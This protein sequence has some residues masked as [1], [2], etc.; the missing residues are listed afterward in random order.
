M[1]G[2]G[3][4]MGKGNVCA[5]RVGDGPGAGERC[6]MVTV[7]PLLPLEAVVELFASSPTLRRFVSDFE[8]S[9]IVG[10]SLSTRRSLFNREGPKAGDEYRFRER[11]ALPPPSHL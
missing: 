8:T 7:S 9:L 6:G 5:V 4:D 1:R 10:L 2:V 11:L 3:V